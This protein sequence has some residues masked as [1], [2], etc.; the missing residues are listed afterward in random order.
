MTSN[1]ILRHA[2]DRPAI[3][4]AQSLPNTFLFRFAIGSFLMALRWISDG[5]P[6]NVKAEKL[7][8]DIIDMGYVAY[9][10]FFDGLLT[11]DKKM[12]E[13]YQE[14]C[15]FLDTVFKPRLTD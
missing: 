14:S 7:R 13:L 12:Q 4:S 8:N 2:L 10:T 1:G 5:G 15:F 11:R 6:T 3:P 9:A